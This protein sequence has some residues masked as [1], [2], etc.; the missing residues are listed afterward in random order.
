M[1]DCC[2]DNEPQPR[3]GLNYLGSSS[4][5]FHKSGKISPSSVKKKNNNCRLLYGCVVSHPDV[6]L[7]ELCQ[8]EPNRAMSQPPVLTQ[9]VS[10]GE[11]EV[12]E[13]LLNLLQ[14][15]LSPSF[16]H[17]LSSTFFAP[18]QFRLLAS[19]PSLPPSHS[20][21]FLYFSRSFSSAS[22]VPRGYETVLET[23]CMC[24][25]LSCEDEHPLM[26]QGLFIL[27]GCATLSHAAAASSTYSLRVNTYADFSKLQHLFIIA[28]L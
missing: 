23:R 21:Q 19:T 28:S 26:V 15:T 16:N 4:T 6:F 13:K 25:G 12:Y 3:S 8:T 24:H 14:L 7:N 22:A 17:Q 2:V 18:F 9:T 27:L 20:P 1:S 10:L 5:G 11:R